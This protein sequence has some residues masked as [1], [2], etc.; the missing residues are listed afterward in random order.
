MRL[1]D[2]LSIVEMRTKLV[3]VSTFG[4]AALPVLF[5]RGSLPPARTA[6][7]FAAVLAVDMGTTAFNSYFDFLA[8]VDEGGRNQEADKVLLHGGV[9]P[10]SALLCALGLFAVAALLGLGLSLVVGWPLLLL[11]AASFLVAFLYSGGPRP[12]SSTPSGELFAGGFLGTVLSLVVALTLGG[13]LPAAALRSLPGA[14][15]IA[16]IL[17]VN[18]FCDREGDRAAGRRTLA[19]LLGG[20]GEFLNLAFPLASYAAMAALVVAGPLPR[21]FLWASPL[22]AALSCPIWVG[23]YRRGFSHQTKGANMGAISRSFLVFTLLSSCAWV[24]AILLAQAG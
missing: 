4:L 20:R 2:F 17:S 5:D 19:V 22:G 15:A 18:N 6:V 3:S 14:L 21:T 10:A 11:G 7:L 23:M 9:S 12:I 24:T 13:D 1:S 16:G 8:G